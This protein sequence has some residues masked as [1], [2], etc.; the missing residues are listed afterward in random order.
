MS[1]V[2]EDV[3]AASKFASLIGKEL[4]TV[5]QSSQ[6]GP[7]SERPKMAAYRIDPKKIL[8]GAVSTPREATDLIQ[9]APG[10]EPLPIP[11]GFEEMM[12]RRVAAQANQTAAAVAVST[13][14]LTPPSPQLELDLGLNDKHPKQ[15]MTISELSEYVMKRLDM[16]EKHITMINRIM[17]EVRTNTTKKV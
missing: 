10:L 8:K 17:G 16:L 3:A 15:F 4:R 13:P 7:E 2:R 11:P 6:M 5:D 1:D 12:S 9:N 14:P